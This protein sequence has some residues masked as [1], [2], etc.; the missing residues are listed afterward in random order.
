MCIDCVISFA[1]GN[2]GYDTKSK[3]G[4]GLDY[5][6]VN[7]KNNFGISTAITS[8]WLLRNSLAFR[9]DTGYF[10]PTS[11]DNPNGFYFLTVQ[12]WAVI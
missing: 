12:L 6:L 3:T 8:P 10:F 9:A 4:I 11:E 1:Q 7:H 2:S 5:A